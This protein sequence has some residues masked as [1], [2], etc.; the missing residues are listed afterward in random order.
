MAKG[1][2]WLLR[3]IEEIGLRPTWDALRYH[4][5]KLWYRC[6]FGRYRLL[7]Y[8]YTAF[9]Q[10]TQ[11]GVPI[12]RRRQQ[13]R[14]SR[15]DLPAHPVSADDRGQPS[16]RSSSEPSDRG[17][18]R[19]AL[20]RVR[21]GGPRRGGAPQSATCN[22]TSSDADEM[23]ENRPAFRLRVGLFEELRMAWT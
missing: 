19:A 6:R 1:L 10:C 9:W 14:L 2:T 7:P 20:R 22:G 8:L 12:R 23:I 16:H 3:G 4:V 21:G 15:G 11:M 5:R 13:L 17:A 18:V